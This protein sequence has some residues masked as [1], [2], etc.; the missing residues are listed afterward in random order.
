MTRISSPAAFKPNWMMSDVAL[1][2]SRN[3]AQSG[4]PSSDAD[5]SMMPV[6]APTASFSASCPTFAS[7][8][9][10]R[11]S[12]HRSFSASATAHSIAA[13]DDSPAP[14]GTL[15]SMYRS[16]RAPWRGRRRYRPA[17]RRPRADTPTSRRGS[18]ATARVELHLDAVVR[19]RAGDTDAGRRGAVP[20]A[21]TVRRSMANGSTKP[22]LYSVCSP[23]RLTRPGA[24]HIPVE[25]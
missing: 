2:Q 21:T 20:T 15:E 9:R 22:T 4:S 8:S 25:A 14:T 16:A 6:G 18:P 5:W 19:E 7:V 1:R 24:D 3:T 17:P 10:S 13:E 11:P 12:S 23:M